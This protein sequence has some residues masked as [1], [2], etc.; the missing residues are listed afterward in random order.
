[1]CLHSIFFCGILYA[2]WRQQ[3]TLELNMGSVMSLNGAKDEKTKEDRVHDLVK[4]IVAI[5]QAILPFKDQLKDLKKSYVTNNWLSK[6]EIKMAMKAYRL[7]KDETDMGELDSMYKKV[8][9]KKV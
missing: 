1:M 7:M 9:G 6:D 4:S 3:L 2:R 8:T 5:E